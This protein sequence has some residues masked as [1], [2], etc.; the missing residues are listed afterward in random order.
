MKWNGSLKVALRARYSDLCFPIFINTVSLFTV[1]SS[2]E[3]LQIKTSDTEWSE[4]S[5]GFNETRNVVRLYLLNRHEKC[6]SFLLLHQCSFRLAFNL[7]LSESSSIVLAGCVTL[8]QRGR[9]C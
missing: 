1:F 8:H 7:A 9:V 5:D 4:I 3:F 6:D 2:F